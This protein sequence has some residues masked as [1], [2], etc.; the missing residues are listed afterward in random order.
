VSYQLFPVSEFELAFKQMTPF[1][2]QMIKKLQDYL[3]SLVKL[4][5]NSRYKNK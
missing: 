4:C 2:E 5:N 1:I 3:D